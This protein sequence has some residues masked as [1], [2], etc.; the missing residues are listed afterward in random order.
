MP[1]TESWGLAPYAVH[2]ADRE[3]ITIAVKGR[4]R[5]A[6]EQLRIAGA[7]GCTPIDQPAPRWASYIHNLRAAQVP[8]DTLHEPHEG[9]FAGTHARY[10]L[11]ARVCP[12]KPEGAA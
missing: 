6:L 2:F 9:P 8:I 12:L 11:R 3:P 4:D 5:W 1:K 10:V 7:K